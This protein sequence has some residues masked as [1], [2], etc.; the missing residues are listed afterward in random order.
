MLSDATEAKAVEYVLRLRATRSADGIRGLRA[1]L[2]V[3]L[4]RFGLRAISVRQEVVERNKRA[5]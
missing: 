5:A 3:A 1:L 4:R 2:K